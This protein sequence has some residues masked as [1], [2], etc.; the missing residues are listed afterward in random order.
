M[1]RERAAGA[2]LAAAGL[3]FILAATLTPIA[4]APYRL[5]ERCVICGSYGGVDAFNNLVMFVPLA[6]G[7]TLAGLRRWLVVLLGFLLTCVIE[8]LQ[9]AV[10]V[11]RDANLGDILANTLGAGLGVLLAAS[12]RRWL[13][14]APLA[15]R[16]LAAAAAAAWLL[17]IAGTGWALERD[18]P[19]ADY[20]GQMVPFD[21]DGYSYY[22]GQTIGATING[23]PLAPGPV[24]DVGWLRKTLVGE[25]VAVDAVVTTGSLPQRLAPVAIVWAAGPGEV[26]ALGQRRRD[27][28]FRVRQHTAR[29][30]LRPPSAVIADGFPYVPIALR[31]ALAPTDTMRVRG[32][33]ERRALYAEATFRGRTARREVPLAASLGWS[34][35]L[36]FEYRFGRSLPFLS[37]LWLGGMIAPFGYW[38]AR[39]AAGGRRAPRRWGLAALG[40]AVVGLALLPALWAMHAAL[41]WEWVAAAAGA[42]AGWWLGRWSTRRGALAGAE[43]AA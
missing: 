12:W 23:R 7:L 42:A 30:R 40:V 8:L 3:L 41:W 39:G 21:E 35:F 16:R 34:F 18:V 4:G 1:R 13:L 9:V 43:L 24:G 2:L 27:V 28:V 6:A 14:P 22:R 31:S 25:R 15:A 19:R 11:G 5:P 37:A 36:P 29:V 20:V 26:V 17:M 32:G 38:G 33:V 10:I